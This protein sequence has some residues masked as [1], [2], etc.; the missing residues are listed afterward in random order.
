VS[1]YD[2]VPSQAALG[3]IRIQEIEQDER[4]LGLATSGTV[5]VLAWSERRG[6]V[7]RGF[8]L[9]AEG[10]VHRF[11]IV[12]DV[13]VDVAQA[14]KWLTLGVDDDQVESE[15]GTLRFDLALALGRRTAPDQ[16]FAGREVLR[17]G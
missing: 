3:Q 8:Q 10:G 2:V 17:C 14:G 13:H 12:A 6:L 7:F 9:A 15:Q 4:R 5:A 1:V 11:A 16:H